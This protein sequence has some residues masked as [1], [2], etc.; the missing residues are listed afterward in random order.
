MGSYEKLRSRSP[1]YTDCPLLND[2]QQRL[3]S[4]AKSSTLLRNILPSDLDDLVGC[5]GETSGF[6][7][8][9]L[10]AFF[11][12]GIRHVLLF[13]IPHRGTTSSGGPRFSRPPCS[14]F[15][16]RKAMKEVFFVPEG[17]AEG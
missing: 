6:C 8:V 1:F 7:A 15:W 2:L 11:L 10:P 4:E 3:T 9:C 13:S 14:I 5:D 17:R 12:A 16:R